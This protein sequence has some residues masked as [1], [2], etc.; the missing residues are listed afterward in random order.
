MIN[1]SMVGPITPFT[2][3]VLSLSG[4]K[5]TNTTDFMGSYAI[6]YPGFKLCVLVSHAKKT[7][8]H[9]DPRE[10]DGANQIKGDDAVKEAIRNAVS[11]TV[12]QSP[13]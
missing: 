2:K 3:I 5:V 7:T 13:R 6:R 1:G 9:T 4:G 8:R 12:P 11:T 10:L